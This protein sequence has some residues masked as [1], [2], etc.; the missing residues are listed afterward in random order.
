MAERK[1]TP[2]VL[3]DVLGADVPVPDLGTTLPIGRITDLPPRRAAPRGPAPRAG[4]PKPE[5]G[6]AAATPAPTPVTW[7]YQTVS[8]QDAHGWRPR[9]VD[10]LE[11]RN[12][13]AGPLIH[14]YVNQRSADGWEL[15]AVASGQSMYGTS[16]RYQIYFRRSRR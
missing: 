16:D 15:V 13:M 9:F 12:W 8:F 5:T 6:E 7:I 10:G 3:A 1:E 2:D 11:L 4:K 14:D